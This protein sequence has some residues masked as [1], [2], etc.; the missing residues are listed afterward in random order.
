[1]RLCLLWLGL[2]YSHFASS[3]DSTFHFT[4]SAD[5]SSGPVSIINSS[6]KLTKTTKILLLSGGTVASVSGFFVY[7]NNVWWAGQSSK[8]HFDDGY[9]LKYAKNLDKVGHFYMGKVGADLAS[10]GLVQWGLSKKNAQL[11][12][13]L[14]SIGGS[15]FVEIKDGYSPNWGFSWGDIA[16]GTAGS[17]YSFFQTKS[18]L[19]NATDVKFSYYK[20]YN[21]Y[22]EVAGY[23]STFIDDYINQTYW[24][25]FS[26]A[27]Y[28][29][30]RGKKVAGW[31]KWLGV[32]VG[33]GVDETLNDYYT[34]F[35]Y[36]QNKGKGKY[37]LM[38]GPDIDFCQILPKRKIWQSIAKK[39]NYIKFPLPALKLTP[40]IK[41][42]PIYL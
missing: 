30:L 4:T 16:A 23:K 34:G 42:Y 14:G 24:L 40:G 2:I 25:S 29:Q 39:L 36:P 41:F 20:R 7:L 35:N 27:K 1:M 38:I 26:P 11:L 9:D 19:L 32:S 12:G 15:L 31:P 28:Q 3:Q 6:N 5:S 13:M 37:E 8:F 22:F 33:F 21:Y 17:L 18:K 10:E